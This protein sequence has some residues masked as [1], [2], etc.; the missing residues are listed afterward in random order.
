MWPPKWRLGDTS[1]SHGLFI[2][3]FCCCLVA[4][5]CPVLC[6]SMDCNPPGSSVYGISEARI[7]EWEAIPFSRGSSQL[8]GQT[9]VSHIANIS[10]MSITII[11][12][13]RE[14][15]ILRFH[16]QRSQTAD[17]VLHYSFKVFLQQCTKRMK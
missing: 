10:P 1:F 9:Q 8:R 7:L 6:D 5:S 4:Q 11:C 12:I 3:L 16:S 2:F 13:N 14:E 17:Y 15:V